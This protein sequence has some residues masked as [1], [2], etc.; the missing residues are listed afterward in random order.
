MWQDRAYNVF[1]LSLRK[2]LGLSCIAFSA[3]Y[4]VSLL[5]F[6]YLD[7][8]FNSA[9]DQKFVKNWGGEFGSHISDLSLQ[10]IG[11]SSFLLCILIFFIGK[12]L[13]S[14]DE[15]RFFIIKIALVPFA[16]LMFSIACAAL[17][18]FD[19]WSFSSFGGLNGFYLIKKANFLP[20]GVT[21]IFS[22]IISLVLTSVILEIS[23]ND[24]IYFCRYLKHFSLFF[25]KKIVEFFVALKNGE[26]ELSFGKLVLMGGAQQKEINDGE[27]KDDEEND[28]DEEGD[29][30]E[31]EEGY[32]EEDE[33]DE[34]EGEVKKAK[35]RKR[36]M[37][38]KRRNLERR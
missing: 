1:L 17:P 8:S 3:I 13:A 7:P 23:F 19:W 5:S 6:D 9:S 24:W 32:D 37:M 2:L 18:V 15:I 38:K 22:F 33:E 11:L 12:K 30:D 10:F 29:Y 16:V 36:M 21:A 27:L 4:L 35:G 34:E 28:E 25:A 14:N 26:I 31:D 20:A